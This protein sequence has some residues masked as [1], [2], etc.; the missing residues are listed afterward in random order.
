MTLKEYKNQKNPVY[1]PKV[2]LE[3]SE[4][5]L[6]YT[7]KFKGEKI[8]MIHVKGFNY[9]YVL[10]D[11]K[12]FLYVIDEDGVTFKQ[13]CFHLKSRMTSQNKQILKSYKNKTR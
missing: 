6:T 8:Q 11:N 13:T 4:V 5:E 2:M 9:D 1:M 10:R 7:H 12:P 3:D